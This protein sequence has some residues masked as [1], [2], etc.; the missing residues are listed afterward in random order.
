[1]YSILKSQRRKLSHFQ[2]S[3]ITAASFINNSYLLFCFAN[4]VVALVKGTD[5]KN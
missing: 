2:K 3:P 1:M 5:S 4:G